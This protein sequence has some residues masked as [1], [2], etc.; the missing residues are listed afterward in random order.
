MRVEAGV[1]KGELLVMTLAGAVTG[2]YRRR[3]AAKTL[4]HYGENAAKAKKKGQKE[5]NAKINETALPPRIDGLKSV[6]AAPGVER[7]IARSR[8]PMGVLAQ[9]LNARTHASTNDLKR[10]RLRLYGHFRQLAHVGERLFDGLL[11]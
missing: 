4:N 1:E 5:G 11:R 3:L 6:T 9:L 7:R 10:I 2:T 8:F